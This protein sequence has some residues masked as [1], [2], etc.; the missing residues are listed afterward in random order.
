MNN[1]YDV[2][3]VGA[4][5]SGLFCAYNI[6]KSGLKVLLLEK[7]KV[8]GKK[9]LLSGQGQCNLTQDG[10]ILDFL[11]HYPE[12]ERFMKHSLLSFTNI[13][14]I[15]F[16]ESSGVACFVNEKQ[17]VFPK[18]LNASD[19]CDCLVYKCERSGVIIKYGRVVTDVEINEEGNYYVYV[20]SKQFSAKSVCL[21]TG[22]KSYPKTGST[23]DG[24]NF[25]VSLGH[26]I[27]LPRPALSPFTISGFQFRDCA[28]ISFKDAKV[29]LLVENG[30]P[31]VMTGDLL[32]THKGLSGPV[33]LHLSRYA[34]DGDS[35]LVTFVDEHN[36][37]YFRDYFF[38]ECTKCR[39]KNLNNFLSQFVPKRIVNV[40][41]KSVGVEN[42]VCVSQ[43]NKST[44][45]HICSLLSGYPMQIKNVGDLN[46]AMATAGG[47]DCN[48]V[49]PK[50]M[51]SKIRS[52]LYFIGELLDIDGDTGGYN[53][54]AAFSTAKIA[55]ESIIKRQEK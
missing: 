19:V 18:S 31:K 2:I 41:I 8:A 49:Y 27:K 39:K 53:L 22:G 33:V 30:K 43:L 4:G 12:K 44:L 51:E 26:K 48:E 32:L 13:E 3:V 21:A 23:G 6:A 25:A 1:F 20:G 40:L 35:L 11:K 46:V 28:G 34:T 37:E 55:A 45:Q 36:Q 5:P 52:G 7:N 54:Q 14:L 24:F 17:K 50:T 10:N 16:F 9:L 47:V 29:K 15:K 42:N 38:K